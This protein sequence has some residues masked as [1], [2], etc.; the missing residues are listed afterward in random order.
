MSHN[1]NVFNLEFLGEMAG[2]FAGDGTL[3]KTTNSF[4]IEI[5]GSSEEDKYYENYVKPIFETIF[6]KKLKLVKR[7]YANGKGYVIGI[8]LCGNIAKKFCMICLN[9]QSAK[10]LT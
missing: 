3:Y 7:Y 10:N 5:R 6:S 2:V 8:R 1:S 9:F 4:V